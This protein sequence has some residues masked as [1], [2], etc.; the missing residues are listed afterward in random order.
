MDRR[1]VIVGFMGS[2]KT[3]VAKALAARLGCGLADLDAIVSAQQH[4]SVPELI[5]E[6]GELSFRDAETAALQV[7]LDR[8]APRIIALGGGAW[9]LERNRVLVN[10]HGCLTV[11]LDAPYDLC[12]QRITNH[13]VPRP[14]ALDEEKARELYR[15]RR[16]PYAL[17][18]FR[19]EVSDKMSPDDVAAR[20]TAAIERRVTSP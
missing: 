19:I 11:W 10:K 12:W 3:T 17:A 4:M 14:L 5:N 2:G 20:I 7:V 15:A 1:I 18:D 8:H 6:Q 16:P 9:T 13:P